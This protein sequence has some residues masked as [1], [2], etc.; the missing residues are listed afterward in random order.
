MVLMVYVAT[1]LW[2]PLSQ[3]NKLECSKMSHVGYGDGIESH[4]RRDA[5]RFTPL[6]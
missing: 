6:G 1:F 4:P 5:R 3:L 2:Q